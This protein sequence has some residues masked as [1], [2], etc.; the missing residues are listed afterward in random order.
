MAT[1]SNLVPDAYAALAV[2]SRE[3]TGS[4]MAVTRDARADRVAV[5]QSLRIPFSP[6]F[7]A[8]DFTPA[9]SLP[10]ASS[11]TYTNV[12]LTMTKQRRVKFTWTGEEAYA[13]NQGIGVLS[14]NQQNIAQAIRTLVNEMS[15][16]V[17]TAA[18]LSGSRAAFPDSSTAFS[19]TL[20]DV[21]ALG[22]ILTDNGAP[23]DRHLI[24]D[25]TAG[26]A[27]RNLTQLTNV[28][29]AG[30]DR[31]L[32]QGELLNISNFAIR[33][34]SQIV[35]PVAGTMASATTTNAAYTVGQTVL[36]LATAGTGVAKV[37]DIITLQGD[38]N[39]YIVTAVS[40]A[41][42]NPASGDSITI[43]APGLRVAQSAATRTI[44][45]DAAASRNFAFS[46]DAILLGTR[47]PEVGPTG[48]DLAIMRET[49]TDPFT[50]ISFELSVYPG[51]H[52]AVYTIGAVWGASVLNPRHLCQLTGS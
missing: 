32:R 24:I 5:N 20:K 33:E 52:M 16:T 40:F 25:T 42:A 18:Q 50:G 51:D 9:M 48:A 36:P 29:Q 6:S 22:K 45:V 39:N 3:V 23:M 31:T 7:T 4:L 30:T 49:I 43:G 37:G 26:T 11:E 19:A 35:T 14:L 8:E 17:C 21:N 15:S 13:V 2:V 38:T 27:L 1:F 34:D 28:N 12:A 47:L 41:G 44:T 10:T 46:R